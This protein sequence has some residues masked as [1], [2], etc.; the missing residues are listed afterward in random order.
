M[1]I[2]PSAEVDPTSVIGPN[3]VIGERC[4]VGPGNKIYDATILSKT[5]IE[6]YSLV[7][8]SIIGWTNTIGKW[9][10]IN[11]LTVTGEDV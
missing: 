3:V 8:G 4:R 7:Q 1:W 9:V 11:G 5:V 2:H 6:G 10:R